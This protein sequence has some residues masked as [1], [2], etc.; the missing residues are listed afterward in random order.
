[1]KKWVTIFTLIVIFLAVLAKVYFDANVLKV[2]RVHF[3]SNKFPEGFDF[4]VLQISDLHNKVFNDNN[5]ELLNTR[6]GV[7]GNNEKV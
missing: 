3:S 1:M 5:K 4:K 2:S 6:E 7:G